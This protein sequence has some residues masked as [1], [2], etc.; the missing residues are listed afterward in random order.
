MAET[1]FETEEQVLCDYPFHH[2]AHYY[3]D[4]EGWHQSCPGLN[5]ENYR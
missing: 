2:Y 4:A 3:V 5:K 1:M